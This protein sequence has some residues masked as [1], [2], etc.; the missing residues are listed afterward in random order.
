MKGMYLYLCKDLSLGLTL[1]V[2]GHQTFSK[3][4]RVDQNYG[5]RIISSE[6]VTLHTYVA[7]DDKIVFKPFLK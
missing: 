2:A 5:F 4:S 3:V 6:N 7:Q 1:T